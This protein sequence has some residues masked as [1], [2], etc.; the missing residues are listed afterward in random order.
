MKL[1]FTSPKD[2]QLILKRGSAAAA[3]SNIIQITPVCTRKRSLSSLM[4][5]SEMCFGI[6]PH[7]RTLKPVQHS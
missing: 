3:A 4:A 5:T 6:H 1:C 2:F 7:T